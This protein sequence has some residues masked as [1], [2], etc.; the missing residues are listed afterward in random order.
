MAGACRTEEDL[1]ACFCAGSDS[2]FTQLI[3]RHRHELVNFC[4]KFLG[5]YSDGEDVAQDICVS[6]YESLHHFRQEA[7]FT[8]WLYRVAINRCKNRYSSW[9]Q[10]LTRTSKRVS[11]VDRDT[12][13]IILIDEDFSPEKAT[14][15]KERELLLRSAI[16]ELDIRFKEVVIL[17]DIEDKSYDEIGAILAIETGTVKSRLARGR[18]MVMGKLQGVRDVF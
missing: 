2:C 4:T 1:V 11:S 18:K 8:T 3:N 12:S 7:T 16:A 17:R 10:R 13:E 9:W 14:L 15:I 6:L 5:D